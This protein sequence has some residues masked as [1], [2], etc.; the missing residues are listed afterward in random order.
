[1]LSGLCAYFLQRIWP[2]SVKYVENSGRN[3]LV[4]FSTQHS[5]SYKRAYVVPVFVKHTTAI[6]FCG[7]VLTEFHDNVE[8]PASFIRIVS[9]IRLSLYG[10]LRDPRLFNADMRTSH[11]PIFTKISKEIL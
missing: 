11:L 9:K 5:H 1:M 3:P 7:Y 10:F 8:N 6:K 2:E 4:S